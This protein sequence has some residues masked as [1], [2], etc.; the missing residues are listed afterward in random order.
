MLKSLNEY[1]E[2]QLAHHCEYAT[3]IKQ[4]FASLIRSVLNGT[5][6]LYEVLMTGRVYL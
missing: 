6:T 2:R 3:Q 1:Y 4:F 5:C